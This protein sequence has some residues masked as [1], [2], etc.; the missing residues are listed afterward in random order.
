MRKM[1]AIL[2]KPIFPRGVTRRVISRTFL[3]LGTRRGW[4]A[5]VSLLCGMVLAPA[6]TAAEAPPQ[7]IRNAAAASSHPAAPAGDSK[8]DELV[9]KDGD[10]VRGRLLEH[11]DSVFV[12][13]S[14]RF[15]VLRV[16]VWEAEVILGQPPTPAVAAE[17]EQ[18]QEGKVSEERWPFSPL[19][20][21]QALKSFFGSWHGRFSV[22]AEVLE[23][24]RDH[25]SSTVEA[26]L[27]RKWKHDEVQISG[28]YDYASV[29]NI[30]ATDMMKAAGVWRHDFPGKLFAVY[31]PSLEWN[32]QFYRLGE[33]ADYVLLQQELG[34]GVNLVSTDTR[35]LRVGASENLFDTWVTPIDSHTSQTVESLFAEFEANLPWRITLT[36]RAAWYY[37]IA[38]STDGWE[39]RFEINKKLT[40][41]LTVGVRHEVRR[42]D[43]DLRSA[44]YERLRMLFGFDF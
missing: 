38:S 11:S 20:M 43:A 17:V 35:K 36:D 32:R 30:T 15:G 13:Q 22:A 10:R 24:A 31:R 26:K 42:N 39:N 2:M 4:L 9:F 44:D 1:N 3:R 40:E 41:T 27:Q 16:P 33:P 37:S 28:R 29:N 5:M 6:L 34:A 14:G 7:V 18:L 23:N 19:A 25:S 12:F 21:T 8:M